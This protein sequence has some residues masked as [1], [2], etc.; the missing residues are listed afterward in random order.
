MLTTVV[1]KD[2]YQYRLFEAIGQMYGVFILFG[3]LFI[4]FLAA[5]LIF[6]RVFKWD[7]K[8]NAGYVIGGLFGLF[9]YYLWALF[10]ILFL[11]SSTSWFNSFQWLTGGSIILFVV[12][13][14]YLFTSCGRQKVK[15]RIRSDVIIFLITF[16]VW[17]GFVGI[18]D[19]A[20]MPL[21]VQVNIGIGYLLALMILWS[22]KSNEV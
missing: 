3:W 8:L 12:G 10:L 21:P 22:V 11:R 1:G 2:I 19:I 13:G 17:L 16:F 7:N 9:V 5:M 20:K 6:I 15:E 14:I 18:L 4:G